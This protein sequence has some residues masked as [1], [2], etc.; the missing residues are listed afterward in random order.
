VNARKT[1]TMTTCP[2]ASRAPERNRDAVT[3]TARTA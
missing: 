3:L 1:S 2:R